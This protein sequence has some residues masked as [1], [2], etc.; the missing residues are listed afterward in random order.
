MKTQHQLKTLAPKGTQFGAEKTARQLKSNTDV[1]TFD[2]ETGFDTHWS[3]SYIMDYIWAHEK[4][5]KRK[6]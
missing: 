1:M 5:K 3:Y 4:V 2:E 6:A